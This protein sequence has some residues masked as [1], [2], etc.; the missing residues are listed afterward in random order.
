MFKVVDENDADIK[1]ALKKNKLDFS[2]VRAI[3][4]SND[5]DKIVK[6]DDGQPVVGLKDDCFK[7]M[8]FRFAKNPTAKIIM[9]KVQLIT[10]Q[11]IIVLG[12][13]DY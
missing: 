6:R 4:Y 9:R 10:D 11:K 3:V 5:I 12:K 7:Y 13:L 2:N 8:R 1:L